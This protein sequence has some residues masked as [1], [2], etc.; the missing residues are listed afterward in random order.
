[1]KTQGIILLPDLL[2]TEQP[3]LV[4]PA[5]DNIDMD[6]VRQLHESQ[7]AGGNSFGKHQSVIFNRCI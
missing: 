2:A 6:A 7:T 4:H 3:I 5:I 1:M